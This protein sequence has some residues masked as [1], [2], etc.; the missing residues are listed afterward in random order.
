MN[1]EEMDQTT[2]TVSRAVKTRF[3]KFIGI[4]KK[5]S[6]ADDALT[7]LLDNYKPGGV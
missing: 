2:I 5:F 6:N 7:A 1:G 3:L 4:P